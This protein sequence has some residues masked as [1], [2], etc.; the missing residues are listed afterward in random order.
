MEKNKPVAAIITP[1]RDNHRAW[2]AVYKLTERSISKRLHPTKK[3]I[4]RRIEVSEEYLQKYEDGFDLVYSHCT[5]TE[6]VYIENDE[7]LEEVLGRWVPDLNVFKP[8]WQ[9]DYPF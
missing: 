2:V 9:V 8:S 7:E 5:E 3:Y 6:I 4:V 1:N